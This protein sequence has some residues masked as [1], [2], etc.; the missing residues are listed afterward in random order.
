MGKLTDRTVRTGR[1]GRHG[2]GTVRGLMLM[3]FPGGSR[4][5]VLGYQ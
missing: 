2:D 3:V 5:W 4:S 1:P